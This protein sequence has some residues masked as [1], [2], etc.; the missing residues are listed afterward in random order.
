MAISFSLSDDQ[1]MFQ[2]MARDFAK[3]EIRPISSHHDHTGEFPMDVLRKAW[4][5]NLMNTHIIN[6]VSLRRYNA[7]Q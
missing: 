2:E 5:L 7:K 4:E 6:L 1:K 3:N